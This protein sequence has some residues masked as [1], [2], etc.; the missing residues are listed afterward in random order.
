M[1]KR[2][3][4]NSKYDKGV[5]GE[6]VEGPTLTADQRKLCFENFK[7]AIHLSFNDKMYNPKST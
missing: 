5:M 7:L 3:Q 6:L 2:K 1:E 4:G